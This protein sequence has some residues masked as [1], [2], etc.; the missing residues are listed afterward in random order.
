MALPLVIFTHGPSWFG[1]EA[2]H[3]AGRGHLSAEDQDVIAFSRLF[4][5]HSEPSGRLEYL[6]LRTSTAEW[7][8]GIQ[9]KIELIELNADVIFPLP[10]PLYKQRRFL[11]LKALGF[12]HQQQHQQQ[13]IALLDAEQL[14]Q[15]ALDQRQISR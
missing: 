13:L 3:I 15:L 12:H 5:M 11:P 2:R 6:R 4:C 1:L 10:D 14:T 7:R 8:L 9:G